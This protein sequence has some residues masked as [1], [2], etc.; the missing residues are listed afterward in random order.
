[1]KNNT[2]LSILGKVLVIILFSTVSF[3]IGNN[4]AP[5]ISFD[6]NKM[7][8]PFLDEKA[9]QKEL[10]LYQYSIKN[11]KDRTYQASQIVLEKIIKEEEKF[12]AYQFS[13]QTMD[14]KMTGQI[15]IPHSLNNSLNNKSADAY[16]V[17]IM[18]R[19]FVPAESYYTGMGTKNAAAVF[20]SNGYI[21]LAPDFFGFGKSDDDLENSWEGRFIKP[22]NVI[23]LIET[24]KSQQTLTILEEFNKN[25]YLEKQ[26]T[27]DTQKIGI[28]AHSN[29]G[30]IALTT[31]E[32]VSE[33]IPTT[34]WAPVTA[35]FPYS[36]LFFTDEMDDEGK[37][38]RAWI[39][40]FEKDYNVFEFS[41]SQHLNKLTGPIQI[42][43]GTADD[44][45][46]IAWSDEFID[47][48]GIEN[49]KRKTRK[50][51]IEEAEKNLESTTEA[52]QKTEPN[53]EDEATI[54]EQIKI[55]YFRYPGTNHNMQ[56]NWQTVVNRDL[57][58]FNKHFKDN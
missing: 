33:P 1:M 27:F 8:S 39:S 24:I 53:S 43:H 26:T 37:E 32:V 5:I 30:Q 14:K 47:K 7:I 28:W 35:P 23:E 57:L 45:A 58:F 12:T 29:G 34:L 51:E 11:L 25:G 55:D 3:V 18:L 36:I 4:L 41:I 13:Y 17:I 49:S 22:V 54:L 10:P 44:A 52:K 9:K 15:N 38:T 48:I 40:L 21:T 31:L 16:P 6:K 20:A 19:G 46:L 42:H 2:F 56:P 50:K